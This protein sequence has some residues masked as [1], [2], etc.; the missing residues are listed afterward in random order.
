M[1]T[2]TFEGDD[3]FYFLAVEQVHSLSDLVTIKAF[4]RPAVDILM[5]LIYKVWGRTPVPYHLVLILLHLGA[6]FMVY[7]TTQRIYNDRVLA[8]WSS[9]LF[10]ISVSHFRTIHFK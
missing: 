2:H 8:L 7:L 3:L 4:G 10:F 6:T 9:I 5:W 1:W